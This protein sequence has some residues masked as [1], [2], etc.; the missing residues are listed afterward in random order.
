M[1]VCDIKLCSKFLWPFHSIH[2][3][4]NIPPPHSHPLGS[5][6]RTSELL[7]ADTITNSPS[8]AAV[9]QWS[10]FNHVLHEDL[11][12]ASFP[13][14]SS[15]SIHQGLGR[16]DPT[17]SLPPNSDAWFLTRPRPWLPSMGLCWH[18]A[19]FSFH[20]F[21][22]ILPPLLNGFTHDYFVNRSYK[23][24]FSTQGKLHLKMAGEFPLSTSFQGKIMSFLPCTLES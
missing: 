11:G 21:P 14:N 7:I 24:E 19:S 17:S 18:G 10:C 1:I 4:D 8:G 13:Y 6:L 12:C 5:W 2:L 16:K 15:W 22:R 9:E 3:Q 23:H 20:A